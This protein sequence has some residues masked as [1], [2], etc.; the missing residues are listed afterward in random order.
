MGYEIVRGKTHGL[1]DVSQFLE[2][3]GAL[4]DHA[5]PEL[6]TF[7]DP[8][9]EVTITR[10]P[11]RLDVMGGI[12]DYSGSLVLELPIAEA[13]LVALQKDDAP[14]I[15]IVSLVDNQTRALSFEM[16][17]ADFEHEGV[18]IGYDAARAY[19]SSAPANAWAAYVAGVFPVLA[20]ERGTRFSHGARLL[21]SSRVPE[22]KGVSSSAALEV[23][24]MSAVA[25]A[26]N[27]E[28]S[29][30]DIALLCQRVE[31]LVVGAP[32][33]VMD[34]MTA[35]CGEV[36]QLLALV[37]QPA[38]LVGSIDLPA[39]LAVWGLDS[40][41]RHSIGGGDYG[42]VR[43]GAFMGLR[44]IAEVA[45]LD[46]D[47]LANIEPHEFEKEFARHLPHSILGAEFLARFGN[48]SDSVTRVERD[49]TY[50]I[51]A[52]A[53]HPIYENFRVRRFAELLQRPGGLSDDEKIALGKLMYESH[54]SYSA[55]GLGSHAT[56]LLVELVRATGPGKGLFGAKITGG[57][58]GGTV[59]VL[60]DRNAEA[61]VEK[62]AARYTELM[63]YEPYIFRGSSPGSAA[64]GHLVARLT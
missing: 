45:G 62:V 43:A 60:G 26:F 49:R 53:R 12:A 42:S 58:S 38:E 21:I 56:D 17:L 44:I 23:A 39:Q 13:T 18:P 51:A 40:G 25:A 20:R 30:R 37:C 6:R 28:I 55:C 48:T 46:A 52:P 36:H 10:A 50:A 31:N 64:F 33:G 7:F 3:L 8:H 57:G 47:Y 1:S 19:F 24:T 29:A 14:R 63:G 54:D 59:A 32:C 9:H 34:Q 11:G 2:T 4:D 15:S 41:V 22:G 61:A 5:L 27:I 35:A 16:P